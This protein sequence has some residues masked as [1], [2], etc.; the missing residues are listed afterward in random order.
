MSRTGRPRIDP[1]H[2]TRVDTGKS[3][4]RADVTRAGLMA[5][6]TWG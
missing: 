6:A 5:G 4:D 2:D 1:H 3:Q